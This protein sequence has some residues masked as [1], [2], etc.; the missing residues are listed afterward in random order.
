MSK[1]ICIMSAPDFP[2]R[3]TDAVCAGLRDALCIADVFRTTR[4]IDFGAMRFPDYRRGD[5]LLPFRSVDWY[6]SGAKATS[7]RRGQLNAQQIIDDLVV[8]PLYT[9][10]PHHRIV[11]VSQDL[12]PGTDYPFVLGVGVP[13]IGCIMSTYRLRQLP[14][15][16][17]GAVIK[18]L[19]MHEVGHM[20]RIIHP[21]RTRALDETRHCTNRCVMRQGYTLEAWLEMTIDRQT[22][23]PYCTPCT[24]ALRA[25][26][27]VPAH[28][29]VRR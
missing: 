15:D 7:T 12:Y 10:L 9:H 13:D 14:A 3:Q 5:K 27:H 28:E 26:S 20:L 19:T 6:L 17:L 29:G 16:I 24:H 22:I 8:D 25:S 18:T 4:V 23:G 11:L 21:E 2:R 1:P